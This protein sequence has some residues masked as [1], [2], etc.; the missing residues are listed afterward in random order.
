MPLADGLGTAVVAL[1]G[2]GAFGSCLKATIGTTAASHRE[3]RRSAA[4]DGYGSQHPLGFSVHKDHPDSAFHS[5]LNLWSTG[6]ERPS[7]TLSVSEKHRI[8]SEIRT[9]PGRSFSMRGE[10]G[11][12]VLT[13]VANLGKGVSH[14]DHPMLLAQHQWLEATDEKH[15]YGAMLFEYF[16]VWAASDTMDSFFYWLDEGEGLQVQSAGKS[17]KLIT[18]EM[19]D[20]ATVKYCTRQE[21]TQYIAE[22]DQDGLLRWP[23]QGGVLCHTQK[24]SDADEHGKPIMLI[25]VMAPDE[26]LYIGDKQREGEVGKQPF[27]HSS[28]LSGSATIAAGSM[29]V[30]HGRL[31]EITPHSGHYRPSEEDFERC[32]ALL[33]ERG[34]DMGKVKTAAMKKRKEKDLS[35]LMAAGRQVR[36]AKQA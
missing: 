6:E 2:V 25:Y 22:V 16:A 26:I 24:G 35:K 8:L 32:I 19:L 4:A 5:V 18:R 29:L 17:D 23:H 21:R 14:T 27:H 11:H 9:K 30:R 20:A 7:G 10:W 3:T 28:F 36:S 15:R 31:L 1:A 13:R 34:I 33:A 12:S